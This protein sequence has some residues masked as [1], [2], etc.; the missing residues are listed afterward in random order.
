M[1]FLVAWGL[2]TVLKILLWNAGPDPSSDLIG[3][4][5]SQESD[6][7]DAIAI[8]LEEFQVRAKSID[9]ATPLHNAAKVGHLEVVKFLVDEL[10][11]N[12]EAKGK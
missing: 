8:G 12:V 1:H 2:V 5:R 3:K 4:W 11:A 7:A 6:M 9:R 10:R